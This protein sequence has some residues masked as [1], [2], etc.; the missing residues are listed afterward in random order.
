MVTWMRE[1]GE[2]PPTNHRKWPRVGFSLESRCKHFPLRHFGFHN[3]EQYVCS[4]LCCGTLLCQQ[5]TYRE[6]R[7]TEH[8]NGTTVALVMSGWGCRS[9]LGHYAPARDILLKGLHRLLSVETQCLDWRCLC[10]SCLIASFALLTKS[11]GRLCT[12]EAWDV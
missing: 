4:A 6:D 1:K 3:S 11:T 9:H 5:D 2:W 12:G 7:G 8:H 10:S